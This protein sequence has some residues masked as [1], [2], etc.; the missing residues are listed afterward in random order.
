MPIQA[1][2]VNPGVI[3]TFSLSKTVVFIDAGVEQP[4]VLA[5]GVIPG[6][7]VHLLSAEEDA[8]AQITLT[9]SDRSD[10][11]AVH[12]ISHGAPGR[13]L[14][15]NGELSLHN[16]NDQADNL[17]AWFTASQANN[18]E[19][20]L[21]GC[22]VAAGD[23]GAKFIARLQA[24]SGATISAAS[25]TVGAAEQGGQWSLNQGN[26]SA[27]LA[28]TAEAQASYQGAFAPTIT[29]GDL[30]VVSYGA[31][32]S[33]DQFGLV[34]LTDIP[35]GSVVFITDQGFDSTS[36]ATRAGENIITWTVGS[37]GVP[38]G[39][40]VT[41][42]NLSSFGTS[43]GNTLNFDSS[44]GDQ[45][46]VY[47]TADDTEDGSPTFIYGFNNSSTGADSTGWQSTAT[48][49]FDSGVPTGLTA[50][51]TNGDG[52]TA[53]GLIGEV[54]NAY[55]NGSTTGTKAALL[56]AISDSANWV[57]NDDD[58][59]I[60]F[61]A[62]PTGFGVDTGSNTP[63]FTVQGSSNLTT[64]EEG[65]TDTFTVKLDS[66]PTTD[67]VLTF[68][69][70]DTT[71]ATVSGPI[72]FT[73]SN[74]FTPQTVTVTGVNDDFDSVQDGFYDI[75]TEVTG[76][77]TY[78]AL[79]FPT[80]SGVTPDDDT[81]GFAVTN[82]S[83]NPLEGPLT[84]TEA[85][86]TITFDLA[87]TSEPTDDVTLTFAS[88]DTTEGTVTETLT[89]TSANWDT[90]QTVTATGI[91]DQ[92]VDGDVA[93]GISATVASADDR[94]DPTIN[95][96]LA[97]PDPVTVTNIDND[98]PGVTISA[99]SGNTTEANAGTATFDVVLN[100]EP[101]SDVTFTFASDDAS[102]GTATSTL[103][104]TTENWDAA[105]QVTVTG[106]DDT[107]KDGDVAYNIDITSES[108]D[109]T[110]N[111]LTIDSVAVTNVDDEV[112][113]TPAS[114]EW[115]TVTG[116]VSAFSINTQ[117]LTAELT[118]IGRTITDTSWQLQT[119]GD[120]NGD[121]QDD[122]LLRNFTAGLNLAWYME[123]GGQA[124]ASEGLIGRTIEDPNWSLSGTGDFDGDGNVDII[125]RNEA[126]D[127]IVAWYMDGSGNILRE[128][129]V[130]RSFGDNNWKIEAAAD[131]NS[132]G[133]ADLLLRN[134]VS[135]QNLLWEMDGGT[136]LAESLFGR[137]IPD[138][139]W[140][141]EGARD[142]DSNGTIDVL[143]RQRSAGQALL[144]TMADKNT[145][146]SE[147]LISGVP[148]SDSQLVF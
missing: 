41:N 95:T 9:L 60:D 123:E 42:S 100:T 11:G 27:A 113:T 141:I 86:G 144:W 13:L 58:A 106:E 21:Y 127:Q 25:H 133:K 19:L 50:V 75:T 111:A 105:Q 53:F 76:D 15:G 98:T 24:L 39:S 89:F 48:D 80:I 120:L 2:L 110:Y 12:I 85:G 88:S 37:N 125:L 54:D 132:D 97:L 26:A 68:T 96:A 16:L 46:L 115:N 49:G 38:A 44:T 67:V 17:A 74:W 87:L 73:A 77:S 148:G 28:I 72:T 36:G 119:T 8:L 45:L 32:S 29:A 99:I 62:A 136:I 70:S 122:V 130:G 101:T 18:P 91:D 55:Y 33:N 71:E 40:V 84:T 104:F 34:A 93:Y 135:G 3:E 66:A 83:Q 140:H 124:I 142:F 145:I 139:N 117:T 59:Q 61:N 109:T 116:V 47:Q 114:I 31:D 126:A 23:L 118:P 92:I 51:A 57:T 103:T 7:E 79:S 147:S 81:A 56:A 14:L 112:G 146:A 22:N 143:L 121:G 52:G 64:T 128:D 131:F 108:N 78:A 134:G 5:Q 35:A 94:Y 20:L 30:A 102:E 138:V 4:G 63:G 10:L 107:V 82:L 129:V 65:G 137:D 69:S 1:S 90:P 6:A 43:N